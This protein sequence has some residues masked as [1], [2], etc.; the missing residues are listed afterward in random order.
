MIKATGHDCKKKIAVAVDQ[1]IT[2]YKG[3][4]LNKPSIKGLTFMLLHWI[5]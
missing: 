1:M 5:N 2:S 3:G 4:L